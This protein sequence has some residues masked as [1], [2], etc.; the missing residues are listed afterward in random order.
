MWIYSQ[1]L[2]IWMQGITFYSLIGSL[3]QSALQ[4][5]Q[6]PMWGEKSERIGWKMTSAYLFSAI[7]HSE[8]SFSMECEKRE[9][10]HWM[11][12]VWRCV[13][14]VDCRGSAVCFSLRAGPSTNHC[15]ATCSSQKR[16]DYYSL[17]NF[18]SYFSWNSDRAA[19]N[20]TLKGHKDKP[21]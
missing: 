19:Q 18:L 13:W 1:P 16:R 20:I 9:W 12:A 14:L 21:E 17:P 11:K 4:S 7:H 2:K 15:T 6:Q 10:R 8:G 3:A 5:N